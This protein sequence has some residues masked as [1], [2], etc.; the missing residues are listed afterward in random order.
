MLK[1][2]QMQRSV[3]AG[4]NLGPLIEPEIEFVSKDSPTGS[5]S[6][7]PMMPVYCIHE[8]EVYSRSTSNP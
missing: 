4:P 1:R 8:A 7:F 6:A 3:A 2:R 5:I